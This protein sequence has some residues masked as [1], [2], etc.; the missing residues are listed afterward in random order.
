MATI[1][2]RAAQVILA[3]ALPSAAA[4]AQNDPATVLETNTDLQNE[5]IF[6]RIAFDGLSCRSY[7]LR[8]RLQTT[9]GDLG[10]QKVKVLN[11][12]VWRE[13]DAKPL[14]WVTRLKNNDSVMYDMKFSG[15]ELEFPL[16]QGLSVS[17]SAEI[18][19]E[20]LVFSQRCEG[21]G[22]GGTDMIFTPA[23]IHPSCPYLNKGNDVLACYQRDSKAGNWEGWILDSRDCKPYRIVQM[24]DG[25]WWFAQNLNYQGMSAKPLNKMQS[26]N[27]PSSMSVT[28]PDYLRTYWCPPLG[29][30]GNG[31][32]GTAGSD[33]SLSGN[34]NQIP[35][36]SAGSDKACRTYGALY[37][38]ATVMSLDGYAAAAN[39]VALL[40]AAPINSESTRRGICPKGWF[41]PSSYDWGKMLNLVEAACGGGCPASGENVGG[42]N[43]NLTSP[44]THNYT[45]ANYHYWAA[46]KCAFRD[47]LSTDVA[48]ARALDGTLTNYATAAGTLGLGGNSVLPDV[49]PN[50]AYSTSP[51]AKTSSLN[52]PA[53]IATYATETNPSWNY[54]LP[55]TAGTDKYGFSAKPAGMRHFNKSSNGSANFYYMGEFAG[56]WTSSVAGGSATEVLKNEMAY[57]RGFRYN[58]RHNADFNSAVQSW[59]W[60]KW[61]GL[62]V[63]CVADQRP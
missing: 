43:V 62:S 59:T 39:D 24:P 57:A 60:D 48:P 44:C 61:T 13:G 42:N 28:D 6:V 50:V 23:D 35:Y 19:I 25:K 5:K 17:D 31:H 36:S 58:Y 2:R 8:F 49:K 41:V 7:N 3:F 63:R 47:L 22:V 1:L 11:G 12:N 9:K 51:S 33:Y 38:W 21:C 18:C 45:N 40:P 55:E 34:G 26:A 29:N 46:S 27:T 20:S 56:F 14:E 54:F 30:S 52:A 10:Y 15:Y 16:P 37:P 32:A 53:T 4:Y